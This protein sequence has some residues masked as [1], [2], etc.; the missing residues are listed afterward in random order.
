MAEE[1]QVTHEGEETIYDG[2]IPFRA[3]HGSHGPIWMF[4]LGWNVGLLISYSSSL[5]WRL[6]LTTERAILSHGLLSRDEEVVEYYRVRDIKFRQ[7]IMQR[8]FGVGEITLIS[9]DATSPELSFVIE[10]PDVYRGR[11]RECINK[12]RKEMGTMQRDGL[13]F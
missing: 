2:R 7:S 3:I 11:V 8:V 12:R 9:D 13:A 5:L 10:S 1:G 4:L 6:K